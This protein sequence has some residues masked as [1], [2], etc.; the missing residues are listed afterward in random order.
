MYLFLV[1]HD[2]YIVLFMIW[3]LNIYIHS[4]TTPNNQMMNLDDSQTCPLYQIVLPLLFLL[5][6][7]HC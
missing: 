2:L 5:A 6:V 1:P 4:L 7:L 3:D